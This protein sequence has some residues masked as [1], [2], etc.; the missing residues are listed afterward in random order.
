M[1]ILFLVCASLPVLYSA[2]PLPPHV[3]L[4]RPLGKAPRQT[5]AVD[6]PTAPPSA[7]GHIQTV[8]AD[9]SI[10]PGII[11]NDPAVTPSRIPILSGN[12]PC[13]SLE[14]SPLRNPK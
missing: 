9:P 10:D 6:R 1:R 14:P 13:S 4:V 2:R 7:C 12:P 11:Y 8:P 5:L 3:T